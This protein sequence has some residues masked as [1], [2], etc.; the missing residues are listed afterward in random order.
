MPP[1]VSAIEDF[2]IFY[3]ATIHIYIIYIYAGDGLL[4]L[5]ARISR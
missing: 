2:E 5:E 4:C 1:Y 3:S